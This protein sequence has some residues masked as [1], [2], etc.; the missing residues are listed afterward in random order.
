MMRPTGKTAGMGVHVHDPRQVADD[1][2]DP[3]VA[4]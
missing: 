3:G 1:E 2:V 4:R